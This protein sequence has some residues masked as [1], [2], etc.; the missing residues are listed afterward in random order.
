MSLF[1]SPYE[2]H[3]YMI[4]ITLEITGNC[5]VLDCGPIYVLDQVHETKLL[6]LLLEARRESP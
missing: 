5:P 4:L 3:L 1:Q 2:I 6:L